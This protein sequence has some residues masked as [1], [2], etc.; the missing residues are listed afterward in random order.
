MN[1]SEILQLI[2]A[3]DERG[4]RELERAYSDH[5]AETALE[6]LDAAEL[7][8]A[9]TGEGSAVSRR[10]IARQ[11]AFDAFLKLWNCRGNIDPATFPLREYLDDTVRNVALSR[12]ARNA[13]M[14]ATPLEWA[15]APAVSGAAQARSGEFKGPIK[16]GWI[17]G[18]DEAP[19]AATASGDTGA[20]S[21]GTAADAAASSGATDANS[22]ANDAAD[23]TTGTSA[24]SKKKR[25]TRLI[26]AGAVALALLIAAVI[27]GAV[28][29][30]R[31]S[32]KKDPSLD[33]VTP[34]RRSAD[35]TAAPGRT[36]ARTAFPG[37]TPDPSATPDHSATPGPATGPVYDP[38]A[39][40]TEQI[41]ET[42][43]PTEEPSPTPIVEKTLSVD[44]NLDGYAET[45]AVERKQFDPNS[46][47]V[48]VK[49][50]TEKDN[51]KVIWSIGADVSHSGWTGCCLCVI[52][53]RYGILVYK[54]EVYQ[55]EAAYSFTVYGFSKE[56]GAYVEDYG[57]VS[58]SM[59]GRTPLPV[60]AMV[61]F[62]DRVNI[63]L[64]SNTLLLSTLDGQVSTGGGLPA[65]KYSWTATYA[66][67]G[68]SSLS[69]PMEERLNEVRDILYRSYHDDFDIIII[70]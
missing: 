28:I 4:L 52:G 25:K 41:P 62:A 56:F 9:G 50:G 11:C 13:S 47:T 59:T 44:L 31:S 53:E 10:E 66:P 63:Y 18:F 5:C 67:D 69:R 15:A 43:P 22:A 27:T 33:R 32:R 45:I 65:E 16:S 14:P 60:K 54:P 48:S 35:A 39:V 40:S 8:A 26:I 1:D 23:A 3:G 61:T 21:T 20:S 68:D 24:L 70:D 17:T 38:T 55:G 36:S 34:P 64:A 30:S 42:F 37:V 49:E 12:R 2:A 57:A 46:F 7:D 58:F 29:N 51:G 6:V 19:E